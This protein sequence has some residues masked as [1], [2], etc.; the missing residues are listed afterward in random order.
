[1]VKYM[2][3]PICQI[4]KDPIWSFICPDCLSR[5]INRWL[6]GNLR[7][8]FKRFNES[9]LRSFSITIDLDGLRC[10][11]CRK[12]R[13]ANICT[14]CYIAEVYGWLREKNMKLA[15]TIYR[16]LPLARDWK[17]DS[18]GGC[19]WSNGLV[20][21]TESELEQRDEGICELCERYSDELVL[22][23]GMWIC[24]GCESFE[25]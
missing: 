21:V 4:C 3:V 19:T 16:M 14:F 23:D 20:P 15:E 12:I 8:A 2:N 25:R 18:N 13:I 10:I 1:V 17:L 5:D 9:F 7:G 6:P 11:R 24:R 22:M